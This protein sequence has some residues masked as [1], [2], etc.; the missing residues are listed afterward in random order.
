[1]FKFLKFTSYLLV[2]IVAVIL[3]IAMAISTLLVL[4]RFKDSNQLLVILSTGASPLKLLSPLITV[5]FL[6]MGYLF[7]S[8]SYISPKAWTNFWQM[9]F[10]IRNN[11]DPPENSGVLFSN[12]GVSAYAQGYKGNLFFE[13]IFI[14]DSR[15][16][17]KI[18][19]YYAK[20]GTI[21]NNVLILLN[22]EKI[23]VNFKQHSKSVTKFDSYRYD[24]R[25]IMKKKNR[26]V[27]PNEKYIDELLKIDINSTEKEDIA[28][29]ALLHQ[30]IT[31]PFLTI[32]FSLFVYI[33][34]IFA[35][36][37][38]NPKKNTWIPIMFIIIMQ[39]IYFWLVNAAGSNE[40][41]IPIIYLFIGISI[42]IELIFLVRGQRW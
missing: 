29:R 23:E 40:I 8:H 6:I 3:P 13:N 4:K 31:S 21:E 33:F 19:S 20:T 10:N 14:I 27:Q 22:G 18:N 26:K 15:S 28:G 35:A 24:L 41:F 2:D 42:L 34:I 36:H 1:M 30:K 39:G 9:E 17:E 32:I 16:S 38:R 25:E 5:S 37:S 11:I 12:N 7:L